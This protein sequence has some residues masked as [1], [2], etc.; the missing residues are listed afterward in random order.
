MSGF[1]HLDTSNLRRDVTGQLITG[2]QPPAYEVTVRRHAMLEP[3]ELGIVECSC[4]FSSGVL[5]NSELAAV[6]GRHRDLHDIA[7]RCEQ[8]STSDDAVYADVLAVL[9]SIR[10]TLDSL[11]EGKTIT[12]ALMQTLGALQDRLGAAVD[13]Y[14]DVIGVP[15][16]GTSHGIY[17]V[18]GQPIHEQ[19]LDVML[20]ARQRVA[21]LTARAGIRVSGSD[22]RGANV[23]VRR[24][25]E[26]MAELGQQATA[27]AAG[28]ELTEV[29]DPPAPELIPIWQDT[30]EARWMVTHSAARVAEDY[31]SG[32]IDVDANA[33]TAEVEFYGEIFTPGEARLLAQALMAAAGHAEDFYQRQAN[34]LFELTTS[35]GWPELSGLPTE[36]QRVVRDLL[37]ATEGRVRQLDDRARGK[38]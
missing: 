18:P 37:R 15:V 1:R 16:C 22:K 2:E 6:A 35:G 8:K 12:R 34:M 23:V 20:L 19:V 38:R 30:A 25:D 10:V 29:V 27:A 7:G 9:R 36:Q 14:S 28:P 24:I 11:T 26:V 32:W 4:G 21:G 3:T 5:P 33:R 13:S 31:W 17:G